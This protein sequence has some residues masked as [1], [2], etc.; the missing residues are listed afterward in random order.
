MPFRHFTRQPPDPVG[1]LRPD[2][3]QISVNS[4]T[5]TSRTTEADSYPGFLP[6]RRGP[7]LAGSP[8]MHSFIK[9]V[10]LGCLFAGM[11]ASRARAKTAS[12]DF[13]SSGAILSGYWRPSS[14]GGRNYVGDANGSQ[15]DA[16]VVGKSVV[17][18]CY[19]AGTS[20]ITVTTDGTSY[21]PTFDITNT[22]TTLKI[23][24]NSD[25]A[26]SLNI[27]LPFQ[28]SLFYLDLGT[29]VVNGPTFTVRGHTPSM[30]PPTAAF[31]PQYQLSAPGTVAPYVQAEGGL[32]PINV[33]GYP[34]V[35]H[36]ATNLNDEAVYFS[37]SA[38]GAIQ[39]WIYGSGG[40]LAVFVDGQQIG[41]VAVPA[42]STYQWITLFAGD[43]QTHQYG[44]AQAYGSATGLYI[45]SVMTIGGTLTAVT[46]PARPHFIAYGDSITSG[47][48]G[49]P[50]DSSQSYAQRVGVALGWAVYNRGLAD[51][52]VHEFASGQNLF[53][54]EAGEA[55]TTDVTSVADGAAGIVVLYGT[56]DMAQ[57]GG[58]ETTSDFQ[59]SYQ[60]MLSNIVAGVS[61]ACPII[62]VGILPR[63]GFSPDTIGEWNAA[64]QAAIAAV[65]APNVKY[66]DPSGWGL[67]Q[68]DGPSAKYVDVD[69][70]TADGLHPNGN[71]YTLIVNNLIPGFVPPGAPV[72]TSAGSDAAQINSPHAYQITAGNAPTSFS[73]SG[74]PPGLTFDPGTGT[75]SGNPTTAGTF[76]VTLTATNAS[77][78]GTSMLQLATTLPVVTL[79]TVITNTADNSGTVRAFALSIPV[80]QTTDLKVYYALKG[81]AQEG[82]EYDPLSG[83]ATIHAGQTNKFVKITPTGTLDG[84]K[85]A[86][87]KLVL[88]PDSNYTSGTPTHAK[89][90]ITAAPT[91]VH[92]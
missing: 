46:T 60:H 49:T 30:G 86:V 65:A 81:N 35:Y 26:H 63:T 18:T 79:S 75:I 47:L 8:I 70:N 53:T 92:H 50:D 71:G 45:W 68:A 88:Q 44:V 89:F 55:R 91:S 42:S 5:S 82:T 74:L 64:M 56:N 28:G 43:G 23:K 78:T 69:H 4:V 48:I 37:A 38:T 11:T 32:A 59:A 12:Y 29:G 40:L 15:L 24:F 84:A 10:F 33:G 17:L 62:C 34:S 76:P 13:A 58:T 51:T 36:N 14:V 22:W 80:A 1:V 57:K 73:A 39:G 7:T 90:I 66:L 25:G 83:K 41:T 61:A 77:G 3:Y 52:T 67:M 2:P 20:N 31:G 54:T 85:Q 87:V 16:T 6:A 9:I 72:I 19:S 27:K 21:T